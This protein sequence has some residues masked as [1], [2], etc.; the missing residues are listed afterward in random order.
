MKTGH[1]LMF[2][3]ATF[4]HLRLP[5]SY[6]LLPVYLFSLSQAVTINWY[7][8]VVIF[9]ALHFFIYPGS[10]IYNSFMDKDTGSIGAL[11]N[12]PP[13]TIQLYYASILIDCAGL[14][15]T[16]LINVQMF[17]LTILYIA[18]SKAY[19]W[20][21]I[22]LKRY[23]YGGWLVVMLFQG[24]YTYLLVNMCIENNFTVEWFTQKNI[25]AI[26]L[27]SLL[28]GAY[29]PLTQIYQHEEDSERGDYTISYRL[30]IKGTFIFSAALFCIATALAWKYF[31]SFYSAL[32]F[33]VFIICLA[34]V[35][36]YFFYWFISVLKNQLK[37]DFT[38]AM[39]MTFISSTCL[40]ICYSLLLY[41]N[42][43]L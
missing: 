12:P 39:R 21:K 14:L 17:F 22:R 4:L 3:K 32:H 27:A 19:S 13:V 25:L 24:G 41:I 5:F 33:Q 40:I 20:D 37:A 31:F 28:I 42:R 36:I 9:I 34:P 11:K 43:Q 8:A 15:L 7:N 26:V 10:N 23:A 6:F 29:Y 16:L 30:G 35:I 18:V 1:H 38:N 2:S